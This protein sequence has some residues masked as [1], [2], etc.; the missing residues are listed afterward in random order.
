MVEKRK[1]IF[2]YSLNLCLII[3]VYIMYKILTAAENH[4]CCLKQLPA[5]LTQ[6]DTVT[7]YAANVRV[8]SGWMH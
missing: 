5:K 6:T 1:V 8:T 4:S 7:Q 3:W 2:C